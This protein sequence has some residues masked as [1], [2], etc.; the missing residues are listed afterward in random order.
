MKKTLLTHLFI[1]FFISAIYL[2]IHNI[3]TY[4]TDRGYSFGN[5]FRYADILTSEWR[6]P[7]LSETVIAY[8][9][10]FFHLISGLFARLVSF[11]THQSFRDSIKLWPYLGAFLVSLGLYLWS[12]IIAKLH[13]KQNFFK[14]VWLIWTFSIPVLQK[15][16]PMFTSEPYLLFIMALTFWYFIIVF[17]PKPTFKKTIILS[18]ITSINILSRLTCLIIWPTIAFGIIGLSLIKKIT[19]KKSLK[20]LTIFFALTTL[21]T[22]W[23]FY[24]RKDKDI[25][26]TMPA[27]NTLTKHGLSFYTDIP[28]KFMMTHPFRL[29]VPYVKFIPIYYST[30]WG[31]WWNYYLQPRYNISLEARDNDRFISN[32]QR[33]KS[34]SLQN[35]I[36]LLPT[37]LIIAGFIYLLIKTIKA[38][39]QKLNHQWLTK[40]MMSIFTFLLWFSY[41]YYVTFHLGWKADGIKASYMLYSLPIFIYMGSIFL[42][43]LKTKKIIF[44]PVFIWLI[45]ATIINFYWS[46]Y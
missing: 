26:I 3:S 23:F 11:L 39:P 5:Q 36:N 4:P 37:L 32:P 44:V 1:L 28:F 27:E 16:M 19:L 13:P 9:P 6:L 41:L 25:V 18:V 20:L 38:V 46:W 7:N 10:P 8:N 17:Q 12:K 42:F 29:E 2:L 33:I 22:G 14:L 34:L 35:Q 15:N 24:L 43:K 31:D 21:L 30:F 45:F 40:A